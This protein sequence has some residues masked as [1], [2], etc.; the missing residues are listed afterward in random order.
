[1]SVHRAELEVWHTKT[2]DKAYT[3][4]SRQSSQTIYSKRLI[5]SELAESSS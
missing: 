5:T 4:A 3:H 1:M 2:P